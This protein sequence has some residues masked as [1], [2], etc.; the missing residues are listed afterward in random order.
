M[1]YNKINDEIIEQIK[2]SVNGKVYVG[3]E[4]NEDFFHDEMPIYGEGIPD[5]LIDATCK[6][7]VSKIM[8]ICNENKIPVLARGAGTGL[9]GAGVS[10]FG[11]V[12]L[13]MQSMNKILSYDEE[14]MVVKVEPG[15]SCFTEL[16]LL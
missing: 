6:E 13:N 8:K 16:Y 14:N 1:D 5:V 3:E 4:I 12:M 11:G 15:V 2:S 7:D 9:T 10:R